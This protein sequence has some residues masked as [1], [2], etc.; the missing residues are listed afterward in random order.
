MQFGKL[1]S[2]LN[3]L[4][5]VF[6]H[7]KGGLA[8]F[9]PQRRPRLFRPEYQK[10]LL[11]KVEGYREDAT[12]KDVLL[13]FHSLEKLMNQNKDGRRYFLRAYRQMTEAIEYGMVSKQ[14]SPKEEDKVWQDPASLEWLEKLDV[15]FAQL[16]F[17][18]L[19]AICLELEGV[20]DCWRQ[21][22]EKASLKPALP[23]LSLV[24][25]INAHLLY[26]LSEALKQNAVY[27]SSQEQARQELFMA[28]NALI[29]RS[30]NPIKRPVLR[31]RHEGFF[32]FLNELFGGAINVITYNW[33]ARQRLVAWDNGKKLAQGEIDLNLL[34]RQASL[35]VADL[36]RP[37]GLLNLI[38]KIVVRG[39]GSS[40]TT[41]AGPKAARLKTSTNLELVAPNKPVELEDLEALPLS[42]PS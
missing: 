30:I 1:G 7:K 13:R 4:F 5:K 20:P 32:D 24:S 3:K 34:D 14:Q 38:W 37:M 17:Q 25:G 15:R 40:E 22:F 12:I 2:S 33:F 11:A 6:Q 18:R 19:E 41:S 28:I 42:Q 27:G 39:L 23:F 16:Y 36:N 26:D 21:A 29:K 10:F 8:F 35:F 9:F 31:S